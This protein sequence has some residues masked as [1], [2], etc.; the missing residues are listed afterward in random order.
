M[1][2]PQWLELPM[3]RNNFLG[4]NDVQGTELP[5][6]IVTG[7]NSTGISGSVYHDKEL[8][9]CTMTICTNIQSSLQ[10]RPSYEV[11]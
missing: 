10:Q 1:I 3:S 6:Y 2:D 9:I 8:N 5:L 11:W 7:M 4:L